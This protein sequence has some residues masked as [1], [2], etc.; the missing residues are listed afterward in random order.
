[1]GEFRIQKHPGTSSGTCGGD[2]SKANQGSQGLGVH[3]AEALLRCE[4]AGPLL[5]RIAALAMSLLIPEPPLRFAGS[6]CL[7][8]TAGLGVAEGAEP[9]S[10][11]STKPVTSA[12]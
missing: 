10:L 6:P 7:Q 9:H 8:G 11:L 2:N 5:N 1:M 4:L 3:R 12:H